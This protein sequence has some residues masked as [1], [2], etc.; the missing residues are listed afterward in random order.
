LWKALGKAAVIKSSNVGPAPLIFLTTNLPPKGSSGDL[1]LRAARGGVFHDAIEMLSPEGQD[2]LRHYA[3]SKNRTRPLGE[4][5]S[6][7]PD[8]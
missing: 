3:M 7:E 8:R 6:S 2:R 5:L 4:L 1:A